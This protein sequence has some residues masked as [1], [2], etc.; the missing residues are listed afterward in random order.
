MVAVRLL[1]AQLLATT[2]PEEPVDPRELGPEALAVLEAKY[3]RPPAGWTH[4]RAWVAIARLG[5]FLARKSD[6]NP[7]WL[8][9]WRGWR[10]LLFLVQG[11]DLA[12]GER[13]G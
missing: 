7:G 4:Q 12:Q 11:Y 6:G 3:G 2:R 5:G 9:I 10:K 13:C 8:T 1:G